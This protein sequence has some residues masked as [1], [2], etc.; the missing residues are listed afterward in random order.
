MG[1]V[2][3]LLLQATR[4]RY[5]LG[6]ARQTGTTGQGAMA[7]DSLLAWQLRGVPIVWNATR[8]AVVRSGTT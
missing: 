8:T 5:S 4:Q 1:A 3:R 7:G 6:A 2:G